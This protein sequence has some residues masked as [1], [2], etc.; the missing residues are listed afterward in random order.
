MKITLLALAPMAFALLPALV[1]AQTA[2]EIMA[3]VAEN[4]TRAEAARAAF[5]YKQDVLVR[6]QR[7]NG[8]LAREE[9]REYTVTPEPDG[10]KREM[11]HFTGKY[12]VNG[13][14]FPIAK[15]GEHYQ[16]NDFDADLANSL[17]D[18]FGGDE[19]SRD[20]INLDLFPLSAKKQKHYTFKLAGQ[21]NYR[22]HEVYRITTFAP[23]P[24]S[25]DS[26]GT[27]WAGEAL[28]DKSDLA[29]AAS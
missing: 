23:R 9:D 14:E 6:L 7:S 22:G 25:E 15:P 17:A 20:G 10:V 21:E 3:R 24:K 12:G 28:I 19:Q 13:K 1:R 5:V 2:D 29:P 26:D 27:P 4:Q 16:D 18:D 8:K 11:V